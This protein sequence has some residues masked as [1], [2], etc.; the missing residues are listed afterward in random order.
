M[1]GMLR[2][3][4]SLLNFA[5]RLEIGLLLL[6]MMLSGAFEVVG[7]GMIFPY[8]A[9]L[10]EPQRIET[11]PF[12]KSVYDI[13]E[14]QSYSAFGVMLS[15]VLLLV[16]VLKGMFAVWLSN[17]QTRF[18]YLKQTD[19]GKRLFSSYLHKPYLYFLNV[20]TSV[21]IG[22]M[23][24]S[25]TQLC[26]GVMQSMLAFITEGVI[27]AGV[28]IVLVY[29]NPV[30]SVVAGAFVAALAIMFVTVI[31][32]RIAFYSRE[33][34]LRWKSM[35]RIVNEGLSSV[36]ELQV[37]GHQKYFVDCYEDECG[38][39]SLALRKYSLLMQLPRVF[40]ETAAVACMVLFGLFALTSS[41]P[42]DIFP[43]LA[44]FAVATVRI[45]PSANRMIQAW[46][47]MT[48]YVP[49]IDII[50]KGLRE[51]SNALTVN[52]S[53][54]FECP[55]RLSINVKRFEY[56]SENAFCLEGVRLDIK[57]GTKIGIIGQ[58]GS[59]K[60]TVV[61]LLLGLFQEFEGSIEVDGV[62]IRENLPAWRGRIGYI[63]QSIYL[64]DATI[65]K[66]VAFGIR[67]EDL[68]SERIRTAV[69]SAGLDA[70][71]AAQ[72]EGLDTIVG[73]R[74]VRLSGGERQRIGIA[75]AL[76]RDPDVL[77]LDEATSALDNETEHHIMKSILSL[78]GRKTVI[79]IAHRLSTVKDCD[80]VY[81]MQNGKL[82]D[83]GAFE[84]LAAR[85]P[86]FVNPASSPC[87]HD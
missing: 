35:I 6:M 73:D 42:R 74:G 37:L 57:C 14:F 16:F 36:K 10:Q 29:I 76:Y 21:L 26:G 45:V 52:K 85:H 9:I 44:V 54:L 63:P 87:F 28:I 48:F 61:D 56:P 60:T 55:E 78:G 33:N 11:I 27:A 64:C 67:E 23:T 41:N 84:E 5:D 25:L 40:L 65:A 20:N 70:V 3:L 49:S 38:H 75:R 79:I 77:I 24:T 82:V 7:I 13:G 47:G 59:G 66:N 50:S 83:S 18:I 43:I 58:S 80:C 39:Y 53:V 68:D 12:L 86:L 32:S 22:N 2:Q 81:L 34:D 31:R 15:I 51:S 69:S 17:Y 72:P 30:Y 19:F 46:N 8:V 62:D 71:V 4:A 1:N